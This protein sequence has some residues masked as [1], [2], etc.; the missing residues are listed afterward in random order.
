MSKQIWWKWIV[1]LDINLILNRQLSIFISLS[2]LTIFDNIVNFEICRIAKNKISHR[3]LQKVCFCILFIYKNLIFIKAHQLDGCIM[4]EREW[5][6]ARQL[7]P[8]RW[9]N[10]NRIETFAETGTRE[11]H[12][13][14]YWWSKKDS[15]REDKMCWTNVECGNLSAW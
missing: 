9:R 11:N 3:K 13:C 2:I 15:W 6:R 12:K 5:Q 4:I 8:I 10:E 1:L 14:I 7:S